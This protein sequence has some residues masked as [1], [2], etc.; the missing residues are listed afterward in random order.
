MT[1]GTLPQGQFEGMSG[2]QI[3]AHKLQTRLEEFD[4]EGRLLPL[5]SVSFT[6]L[7]S[8]AHN[9]VDHSDVCVGGE[10][11]VEGMQYLVWVEPIGHEHTYACAHCC[12]QRPC[13]FLAKLHNS[14]L[15]LAT[16]IIAKKRRGGSTNTS[17]RRF[18]TPTYA[19][20]PNPTRLSTPAVR[21]TVPCR[22][23]VYCCN[24]HLPLSCAPPHQTSSSFPFPPPDHPHSQQPDRNDAGGDQECHPEVAS[25]VRRRADEAAQTCSSLSGF[26]EAMLRLPVWSETSRVPIQ[27]LPALFY[28]PLSALQL[29]R[30]RHLTN[31]SLSLSPPPPP[32][33]RCTTLYHGRSGA[34]RMP[35]SNN[36]LLARSAT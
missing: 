36:S 19:T 18:H 21:G 4:I 9:K 24:V 5:P 10:Q 23:R 30:H 20:P 17:H 3:R 15:P 7:H 22:V 31:L 29:C 13:P 32:F 34:C 16:T 35:H 6:L 12:D 26:P 28:H 2:D 27:C 11:R 8:S 33:P 14:R 25:K 1:F